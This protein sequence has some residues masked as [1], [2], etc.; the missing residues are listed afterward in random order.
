MAEI[1][2]IKVLTNGIAE[3]P[4]LP[5]GARW[6]VDPILPGNT[7]YKDHQPFLMSPADY[8]IE[9]PYLGKS[10]TTANVCGS[11]FEA[12]GFSFCGLAGALGRLLKINPY[13][14]EPTRKLNPDICKHCIYSLGRRERRELEDRSERTFIRR[15][16]THGGGD[17]PYPSP[18][19]KAAIEEYKTNKEGRMK[20]P[21]MFD[22]SKVEVHQIE[23]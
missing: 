12:F 5:T 3:R 11:V 6:V 23:L 16:E 18:T 7:E 10:C 1:S 14:E 8:G 4:S 19:W 20:F 17:L 22:E 15:G 2:K 13:S 21:R 9:S